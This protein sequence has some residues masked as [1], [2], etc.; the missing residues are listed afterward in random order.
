M[1]L[2]KIVFLK[3]EGVSTKKRYKLLSALSFIEKI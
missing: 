2:Q 1:D 3:E